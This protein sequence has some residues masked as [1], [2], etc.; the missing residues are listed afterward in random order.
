LSFPSL[1]HQR[2]ILQQ[3]HKR[4]LKK[5]TQFSHRESPSPKMGHFFEYWRFLFFDYDLYHTHFGCVLLTTVI[6]LI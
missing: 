6:S 3:L 1:Q 2:Q 5:T 4:K